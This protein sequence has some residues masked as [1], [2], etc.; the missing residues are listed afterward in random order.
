LSKNND[1]ELEVYDCSVHLLYN[2]NL[3]L[4]DFPKKLKK[5]LKG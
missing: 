2:L 3:V 1:Y 4:L 5:V